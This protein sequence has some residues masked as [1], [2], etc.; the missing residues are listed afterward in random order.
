MRWSLRTLG[1]LGVGLATFALSTL[2]GWALTDSDSPGYQEIPTATIQAVEYP[3][4]PVS[5]DP[6]AQSDERVDRLL[7]SEAE[8]GENPDAAG[9]AGAATGGQT[10]RVVT[11]PAEQVADFE[12]G[13]ESGDDGVDSTTT[14]SI[15][16][17]GPSGSDSGEAIPAVVLF[18]DPRIL[19]AFDLS[20]ALVIPPIPEFRFDTCAGTEPG[21]GTPA[22][23]PEGVGGTILLIDDTSGEPSDVWLS[24]LN[25]EP[26]GPDEVSIRTL[27]YATGVL[28][29]SIWAGGEESIPP[30]G[31]PTYDIAIPADAIANVLAGEIAPFC[32]NL[33]IPSE[34]ELTVEVT[35]F[36]GD[37]GPAAAE[38]ISFDRLTFNHPGGRPPTGRVAYGVDSLYVRTFST[39]QEG[40]IVEATPIDIASST[41][42]EACDPGG[43]GVDSS[44]VLPSVPGLVRGVNTSSLQLDDVSG[45]PYSPEYNQLEIHHLQLATGADYA[46][47]V[48][49]VDPDLG[50]SG[51]VSATEASFVATPDTRSIELAVVGYRALESSPYDAEFTRAAIYVPRQCSDEFA[52][53]SPGTHTVVQQGPGTEFCT[54][55]SG[56]TAIEQNGGFMVRTELY[57]LALAEDFPPHWDSWIPVDR[58]DLRCVGTCSAGDVRATTVPVRGHAFTASGRMREAVGYIDI[59]ARFVAGSGNGADSWVLA[60]HAP[61][62]ATVAEIDYPPFIWPQRVA[63]TASPLADSPDYSVTASFT[64]RSDRPVALRGTLVPATQLDGSVQDPCLHGVLSPEVVDEPIGPLH[65]I[66]IPNLCLGRS[67]VLELEATDEAGRTKAEQVT[68]FTSSRDWELH[69]SATLQLGSSPVRPPDPRAEHNVFYTL[70]N[71]VYGPRSAEPTVDPLNT[72]L[73]GPLP[74]QT[75]WTA[76]LPMTCMYNTAT[77]IG[78]PEAPASR[79]FSLVVPA[80]WAHAQNL[81]AAIGAGH[82]RY[83]R[84]DPFCRPERTT[85]G[86]SSYVHEYRWDVGGSYTLSEL[87]SGV[88][89]QSADGLHTIDVQGTMVFR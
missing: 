77:Y 47:C 76:S 1:W 27:V 37:P 9:L 61:Y 23:C 2:A 13:P 19:A 25:C 24:D 39:A 89:I 21:E 78:T 11:V 82:F 18:D 14:T 41:P 59:E 45:W 28:R 83:S 71:L 52:W 58:S 60:E 88:E 49:F 42:A 69:L 20:D 64:V 44:R 40:V 6:Q 54:I 12:T 34:G 62:E 84:G 74:V 86:F 53:P 10:T 73:D 4:E 16:D 26:T 75:G 36:P 57:P 87:L 67:F 38:R 48:Y 56:L 65:R 55:D 7:A 33:P 31:T 85:R 15:D 5:D 30:S 43:L 29:A 80:P 72:V 17:D 51:Q 50:F 22:G 35:M 32:M 63:V 46:L 66:S 81:S 68:I 3:L 79:A 8:P 70:G